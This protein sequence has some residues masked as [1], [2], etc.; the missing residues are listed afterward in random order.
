MIFSLCFFFGFE[1]GWE[2]IEIGWEKISRGSGD[3]IQVFCLSANSVTFIYYCKSD[4]SPW[5]HNSTTEPVIFGSPY[6]SGGGGKKKGKKGKNKN[7]T[8]VNSDANGSKSQNE[9]S[10]PPTSASPPKTDVPL[11]TQ[12]F[13]EWKQSDTKVKP[14][15][16]G[17]S[18]QILGGP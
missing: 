1:L 12:Q 8:S 2:K 17:A 16:Q 11:N 9:M 15:L 3:F 7:N 14:S 13:R 6:F 10:P 18:S 4:K 5:F